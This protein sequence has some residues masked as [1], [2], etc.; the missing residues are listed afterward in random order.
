M[1]KFV[2]SEGDEI[3]DGDGS[4]LRGIEG[5]SNLVYLSVYNCVPVRNSFLEHLH[6]D[7]KKNIFHLVIAMTQI[8]RGAIPTLS[9]MPN[10][11]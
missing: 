11:R 10:L 1:G 6:P 8:D 3:M 4:W 9:H 5:L 7:A 2:D